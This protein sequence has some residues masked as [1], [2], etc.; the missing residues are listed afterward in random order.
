MISGGTSKAVVCEVELLDVSDIFDKPED[1]EP[2]LPWL[3]SVM[4]ERPLLLILLTLSSLR[5]GGSALLAHT[6]L[7]VTI[8]TPIPSVLLAGMNSVVLPSLRERWVRSG[9]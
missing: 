6:S 3:D 9:W 5:G 8:L 7:N 1:M 2:V 4:L